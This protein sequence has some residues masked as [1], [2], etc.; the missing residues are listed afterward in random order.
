MCQA[1]MSAGMMKAMVT[2]SKASKK[3]ALLM[4]MRMRTCQADTGRRSMRATID[5]GDT[6]AVA[7]FSPDM[8]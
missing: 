3:V 2:A 1:P 6:S 8:D 7:M 5:S 4:M